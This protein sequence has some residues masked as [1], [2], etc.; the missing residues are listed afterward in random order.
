MRSQRR[1]LIAALPES[2]QRPGFPKLPDGTRHR[3]WRPL[4]SAVTGHHGAPPDT[5]GRDS[6]ATL[7]PDFGIADRIA[8]I[9]RGELSEAY[10]A[11][12][13]DRERIGLLMAGAHETGAATPSSVAAFPTPA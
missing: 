8:V 1:T 13:I 12:A 11:D 2:A 6:I 4:V 3:A 9:S 7:R 10:P 5:C